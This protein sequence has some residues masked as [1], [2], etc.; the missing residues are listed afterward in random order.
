MMEAQ[1]LTLTHSKRKAAFD[2][3]QEIVAAEAP[4][5]FLVFPNSLSAVS[6][7]LHNLEPAIVRPQIYWNIERLYLD[8]RAVSTN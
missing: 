5:I 8:K 1:A 7:D 6:P 3:V 2:R 4:M